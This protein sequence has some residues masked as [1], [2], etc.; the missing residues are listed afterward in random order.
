M[1][2]V[3]LRTSFMQ[4]VQD[5]LSVTLRRTIMKNYIEADEFS[6]S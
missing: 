4:I 2:S 1:P 6:H 5:G 3:A